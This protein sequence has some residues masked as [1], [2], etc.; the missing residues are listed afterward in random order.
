MIRCVWRVE[1]IPDNC[2]TVI[3]CSIYNKGN[4]TVTENCTGISLLDVS[5]KVLTMVFFKKKI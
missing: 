4:P 1:R 5:Y 2:N 3:I